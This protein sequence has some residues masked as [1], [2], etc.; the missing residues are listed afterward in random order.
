MSLESETTPNNTLPVEELTYEQAF[1]E[2][3]VI[4]TAL[5]SDDQP[6]EQALS[7]YERGQALA[8]FCAELLDKAELKVSELAEGTPDEFD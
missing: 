4:V 6:L 1:A 8:R 7:L 5:E 3:E 2:L